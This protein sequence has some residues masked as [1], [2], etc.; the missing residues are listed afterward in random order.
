M[1]FALWSSVVRRARAIGRRL[2]PPGNRT[3][4]EESGGEHPGL[5]SGALDRPAGHLEQIPGAVDG[6]Q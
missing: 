1:V 6:P 3:P 5:G 4:I 2:T